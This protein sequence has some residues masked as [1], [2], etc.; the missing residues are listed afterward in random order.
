[1]T[2]QKVIDRLVALGLTT[3]EAKVFSALTRLG[4]AGV[5]EIH[6]VAEVPR[7]AVYG[8][9]DKL[10]RRGII[11]TST[12]RPKKFRALPPKVAVSKIESELRDAVK[13]AKDGL[14]EL[15]STPHREASDVRIWIVKGRARI[16]A[17]LEDMVAAAG[18]ELMVAGTPANMMAFVDIWKMAKSRKT[19]VM[20]ATM[21][22]DKIAGLAK[23]GEIVRPRYHVK[24][25]SDDQPK[26]L[27][28][29]VDRRII[30]FASE[31]KDETQV[32]DMTAFWTD[33]DSIVRFLNYLIDSMSKPVKTPGK[34]S[35]R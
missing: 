35:R 18:S 27:F 8:T 26:V 7:S 10:E 24:L 15:A 1:M 6:A 16:R 17:R 21:D 30:L 31:Y 4:E 5:S 22:P 9:L 13:D 2:H 19:R 14:E 32:E 29:R 34:A 25:P 23:F 11:E 12:G 3:Y 20:F 33:D 28:V